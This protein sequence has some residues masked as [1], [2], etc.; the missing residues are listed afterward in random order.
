[1]N[2]A[3]VGSRSFPYYGL[4]KH[5]VDFLEPTH[6][7]SGG[8]AGADRLGAQYAKEKGI[9]LT[10]IIPDWSLGKGA[11]FMRNKNI[12]DAGEYVIAFWDGESHGT[13]NSI[14]LAQKA[15]KDHLVV[16]YSLPDIKR[17]EQ[18]FPDIYESYF[19]GRVFMIDD[20][21]VFSFKDDVAASTEDIIN[22]IK[23]RLN[24]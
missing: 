22:I 1:M 12:V 16:L 20:T 18:A 2:V 10:E 23:V 19:K 14:E 3:I 11:G 7:I 21:V 6:I 24:G 13:A 4:L 9:P 15:N 5:Y 8:A 17:L